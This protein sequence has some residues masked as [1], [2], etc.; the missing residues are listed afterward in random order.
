[1][2]QVTKQMMAE[3]PDL[4]P[5]IFL[6]GTTARNETD[7]DWRKHLIRKLESINDKR[8]ESLSYFDPFLRPWETDEDWDEA[9][10]SVETEVKESAPILIFV[11]TSD[12]HGFFSI[13][14]ITEYVIRRHADS[15]CVAI[16]DHKHS[17]TDETKRSLDA[18]MKRWSHLGCTCTNSLDG[19]ISWLYQHPVFWL[20][21]DNKR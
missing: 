18:C 5:D 19:V 12:I 9:F 16:I 4:A 1:M 7:W 13:E 11:L 14:E 6:G 10:Q 21:R 20:L 15:I 8:F 2:I 3:Q 17:F